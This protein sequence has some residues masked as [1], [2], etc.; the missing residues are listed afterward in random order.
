MHGCRSA[1]VVAPRGGVHGCSGGACVIARGGDMHGFSQGDMHGCS[2]GVGG[3]AWDTTRYGDTINEWAV[4]IASYW[5]AF[6]WY[7]FML[8]STDKD[9]IG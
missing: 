2:R 7:K 8:F 5:N 1:C 4:C 6:L 3:H 9:V